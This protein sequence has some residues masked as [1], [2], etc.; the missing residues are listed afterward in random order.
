MMQDLQ[1]IID[2]AHYVTFLT[3][4]GVSTASGIP[5]YRSKNGLYSGHKRPEELLSHDYLMNH[6]VDFW[7]FVKQS[8]YFPQAQPN[9][10]HQKMALIA[11]QKGK[12]ITQNIDDLDLKANNHELVQFHGT[13]YQTTCLKCGQKVDWHDY[14]ADYHHQNCGGV[15]RPDIVLYGE[16]IAQTAVQQAVLAVQQADVLIVV[17][18]SFQVYPF[19]GLIQYR[20]PQAQLVAVNKTPLD[21]GADGI[22][23]TADAQEIFAQLN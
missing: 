12:V 4:A 2:Q 7:Q 11:N 22:M 23:I 19:A 20:Q 18:T 9:V 13:L 21:V 14:L 17:G 16:P 5:D 1:T 3:G 6:P 15:I 10:I 8:L